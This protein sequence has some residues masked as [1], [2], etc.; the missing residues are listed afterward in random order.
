LLAL[1][2]SRSS[3]RCFGRYWFRREEQRLIWWFGFAAGLWL[4]PCA[5]GWTG[6]DSYR[7]GWLGHSLF[8]IM[9]I[10]SALAIGNGNRLGWI[11]LVSIAAWHVSLLESRNY[12]DYVVDPFFFL[13]AGMAIGRDLVSGVRRLSASC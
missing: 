7:E 3:Q 5:L 9:A 8:W 4:Y 11:L 12:W 2:C 6:F 10:T 13:G 1:F